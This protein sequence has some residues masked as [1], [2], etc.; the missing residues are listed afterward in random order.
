MRGNTL[1]TEQEGEWMSWRLKTDRWKDGRIHVFIPQKQEVTRINSM[2]YFLLVPAL[3][4]ELN[5]WVKWRKLEE[6]GSPSQSDP[7]VSV[8]FKASS[9]RA[10]VNISHVTLSLQHSL[11]LMKTLAA[12][13]LFFFRRRF[14]REKSMLNSWCILPADSWN[15]EASS[16]FGFHLCRVSLQS[17]SWRKLGIINQPYVVKSRK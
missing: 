6:E 17:G 11:H 5:Y 8:V 16:G 14:I 2:W 7:K 10:T 1:L 4:I 13:Q 15:P 9:L 3:L 12:N